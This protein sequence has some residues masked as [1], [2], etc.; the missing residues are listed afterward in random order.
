MP[1]TTAA[2]PIPMSDAERARRVGL[3]LDFALR[4]I[5][6][7]ED[8]IGSNRGPEIDAW[9]TEFGSPVG[10]FWCALAVG[11]ARKEGGLWIPS[12]DVGSCDEWVYQA[13]RVGLSIER[14][15]PGAAVVY[16][17]H[18]HI[19]GGRYAGQLDAVHIGIILRT[20]PALLSIEGNT[21]IGRF[22]RSGFVQALK[23][24]DRT[25]V[26]AYIAPCGE[27]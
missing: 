1:M 7:C 24:V 5:G 22:D 25:R 23:E 9:A 4:H 15:Q 8:P 14:P 3:A 26:L 11:K 18:N 17:N 6:V 10:S 19:E 12:H 27:L 13:T 21:V 20:T 16:T 2:A